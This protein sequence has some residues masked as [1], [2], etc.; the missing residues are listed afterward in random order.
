[1]TD[2]KARLSKVE[3]LPAPDLWREIEARTSIYE[4]QHE[5]ELFQERGTAGRHPAVQHRLLDARSKAAAIC[6]ALLITAASLYG[7]VVAFRGV[8]QGSGTEVAR[9]GPIGYVGRAIGSAR[10]IDNLDIFTVNPTTVQSTDVTPTRHLAEDQAAWTPDGSKVAFV[11]EVGIPL[12]KTSSTSTDALYAMNADGTGL[13][14]LYTCPQGNEGA[15]PVPSPGSAPSLAH[16]GRHRCRLADPAWSP[17]GTRIALVDASLDGSLVVY[18][19]GSGA[20]SRICDAKRCGDGIAQPTWSPEGTRIAF[21]NFRARHGLGSLQSAIWVGAADGSFTKRLT[22]G[23]SAPGCRLASLGGCYFDVS[24][25]WSPD[26]ST[27][28]FSRSQ[29]E[30]GGAKPILPVPFVELIGANGGPVR[31]VASCTAECAQNSIPAFSPNGSEIA[32]VAGSRSIEVVGVRDRS[33]RVIETC[34][35]NGVCVTP[36]AI[37]WAPEGDALAFVGQPQVHFRS[38]SAVYVVRANGQGLRQVADGAWMSLSWLPASRAQSSIPSPPSI[39]A[40]PPVA[41]QAARRALRFPLGSVTAAK[42]G[43]GSL[44]VAVVTRHGQ[45][46]V[47]RVD[48]VT[49]GTQHAFALPSISAGEWGGKGIAIGAG[50]VWVAGSDSDFGHA[51]LFRIDPATDTVDA[52]RLRGRGVENIAFDAGIL[53]ALVP[54]QTGYIAD[55]VEMNPSTQRVVSTTEFRADWYGGIF[56]AAGTVWVKEASTR[57]A[58]VVGGTIAQIVPGKV[59]PVQTGG[60]FAEPVTDGTSLWTPFFGDRYTMKV[61][62]GIARIDPTTGHVLGAWRTD[63]IGY[64]MKLGIDRGIWFLSGRTLERFNPSNGTVDVKTTLAGTPIFI[65]PTTDGLWV[66][67]YQ[68]TLIHFVVQQ[69]K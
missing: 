15:H 64:D 63:T 5:H 12:T 17:D 22:P 37:S 27:I 67:T 66:G 26:G 46:K 30:F 51:V 42:E 38:Q 3:G 2:L 18:D 34:L 33:A 13:R 60:S 56:P 50:S 59:A 49:G 41:L 65:S 48:P 61:S 68:G 43:F 44:W 58:A 10:G 7:V 55:I 14:Q 53:W 45:Q 52:I 28:A 47:L 40:V 20:L 4:S 21:S 9:N 23:Q 36:A 24:P 35:T 29:G 69:A 57:G 31:N 32:F 62:G 11:G 54:Q 6:V 19:L 16:R 25:A 39:A 1:M 8:R